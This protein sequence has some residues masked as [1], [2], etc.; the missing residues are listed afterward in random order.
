MPHQFHSLKENPCG[1]PFY[2]NVGFDNIP[3]SICFSGRAR[4]T[5]PLYTAVFK[6]RS[7]LLP[8]CLPSLSPSEFVLLLWFLLFMLWEFKISTDPEAVIHTY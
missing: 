1:F 8:A 6:V 2:R 4:K 3:G 5:T 7:I